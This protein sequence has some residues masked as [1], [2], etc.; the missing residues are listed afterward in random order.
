VS[1][2]A[3][4]RHRRGSLAAVDVGALEQFAACTATTAPPVTQRALP[5]QTVPP[6]SPTFREAQGDAESLVTGAPGLERIYVL[7]LDDRKT[8]LP[9]MLARILY[10]ADA[11][12]YRQ[13]YRDV[14]VGDNDIYDVGC[15]TAE[16]GFD[17][18]SG[19][20]EIRVDE[21]AAVLATPAVPLLPTTPSAPSDPSDPSAPSA[22][23]TP[24]VVT[25]SFTG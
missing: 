22:P 17:L 6:P 5:G 13:V 16:K 2:T 20:G 21:L 1:A 19:L 10:A 3:R 25:P 4:D 8:D 9:A 11:A 18:A 12:R 15:C 7:V 23:S 24:L 14:T